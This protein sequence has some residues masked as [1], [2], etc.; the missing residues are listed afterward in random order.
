MS[1][2]LAVDASIVIDLLE[3]FGVEP[4]G[5][6]LGVDDTVSARLLHAPLVTRDKRLVATSGLDV[7]TIVP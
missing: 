4:I 6:L 3:R 5:V 2:V 1:R 7:Q